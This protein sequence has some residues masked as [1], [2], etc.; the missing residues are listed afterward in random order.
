MYLEQ[1]QYLK[2]IALEYIGWVKYAHLH[3]FQNIKVL[4]HLSTTKLYS[5]HSY[6]TVGVPFINYT[7]TSMDWLIKCPPWHKT[8][9]KKGKKTSPFP[10][11][12]PHGCAAHVLTRSPQFWMLASGCSCGYPRDEHSSCLGERR[13]TIADA[14]TKTQSWG[15]AGRVPPTRWS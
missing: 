2:M 3:L 14:E 5:C 4:L 7:S 6:Y 11:P 12:A 10:C 15:G 9:E 8:L 13:V 1:Q